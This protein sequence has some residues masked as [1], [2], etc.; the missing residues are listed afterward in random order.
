MPAFPELEKEFRKKEQARI[1]NKIQEKNRKLLMMS[2]F[3]MSKKKM[4]PKQLYRTIRKKFENIDMEGHKNL[5]MSD[6]MKNLIAV[7]QPRKKYLKDYINKEEAFVT[8]GY[9]FLEKII[10]Q[11]CNKKELREKYIEKYLNRFFNK[12]KD[13]MIN[14]LKRANAAFNH[15]L[16]KLDGRIFTIKVPDYIAISGKDFC[17]YYTDLRQ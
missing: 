8:I 7:P 3:D 11:R 4:E 5:H 12:R 6:A 9:D 16:E 17:D 1:N 10:E 14:C 15:F 13:S 2:T